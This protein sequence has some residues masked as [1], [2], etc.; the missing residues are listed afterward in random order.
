[1]PNQLS[2]PGMWPVE[3]PERRNHRI[4]FYGTYGVPLDPSSTKSIVEQVKEHEHLHRDKGEQ[5]DF[6]PVL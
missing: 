3:T 1:M 4:G 5:G 6:S 2:L